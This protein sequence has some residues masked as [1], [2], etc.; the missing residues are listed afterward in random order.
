MDEKYLTR[1]KHMQ[2]GIYRHIEERQKKTE[3]DR[4]NTTDRTK[5]V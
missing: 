2:E 1:Q 4:M 3:K 5:H